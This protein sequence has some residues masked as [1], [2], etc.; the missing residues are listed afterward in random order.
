[1][2]SEIIG[3]AALLWFAVLAPS[4]MFSRKAHR[5]MERH[6]PAYILLAWLLPLTLFGVMYNVSQENPEMITEAFK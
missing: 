1:M 3:G 6:F 2:D 4:Y 5:W